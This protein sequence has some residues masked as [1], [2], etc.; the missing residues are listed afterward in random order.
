MFR[1]AHYSQKYCV[2]GVIFGSYKFKQNAPDANVQMENKITY[3]SLPRNK[4]RN[5]IYV[6]SHF[7]KI[8]SN[9]FIFYY[10][11]AGKTN[12]F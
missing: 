11:L 2:E 12:I 3:V 1:V 9:T 8:L 10:Q 6:T 7:K 4:M 5:K